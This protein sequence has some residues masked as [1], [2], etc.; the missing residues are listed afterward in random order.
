MSTMRYHSTR[1]KS[2]P[3]SFTE[4]LTGGIAPD[5]GLYMPETIPTRTEQ[6]WKSLAS[7]SYP[8]LVC[9]VLE[10]FVDEHFGQAT[11]Q[12]LAEQSVASFSDPA[13]APLV[14]LEKENLHILEL[15][16]GP[17]L[18]FK[19][20]ALQLLGQLL[21]HAL[22]KQNKRALIIGATSGDTGSAAIEGCRHS[23]RIA[24]FMLHP[25]G[26]VSEVQRRQM[27]TVLAPHIHNLAIETD[28][29]GCQQSVKT[30]L[31]EPGIAL[32]GRSVVAVNSINWARIMAQIVYYVHIALKLDAWNHPLTVVV[33]TGN[34]GNIF[35]A[36]MA[37]RMGVPLHRLIVAT[38]RNDI[39]HR[40]IEQND[41]SR[42]EVTPS[43][44]PSMDIQV[45]S[46][47]ERLLYLLHHEDNA[48]VASLMEQFA[49][50]G[51]MP[52]EPAILTPLREHFSSYRCS[53][54]ETLATIA[55][56]HQH[57]GYLADPHTA[58]AIAAARAH[59]AA[60]PSDGRMVVVATA[61][62]AKFPDAI[63]QAL[64]IEPALPP[65]LSD[66]LS[67]EERY[68]VLPNTLESLREYMASHL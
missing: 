16:H 46:N 44:S 40:F 8:E 49:T 59:Q 14:E 48:A 20:L 9:A 58:T 64:D 50:Q 52:L 21:Q 54:E 42:Q 61:H 10:P 31:R 1:G 34:F 67:R 57:T 60:Q 36:F 4:V 65:H 27:T 29:D 55:S 62:P 53:D 2:A 39:L 51:T 12:T 7:C 38:N 66:L 56:L 25:H 37:R 41:Y 22:E 35:A 17:T 43:L 19:D 28:F 47:L 24:L 23:D 63:F 6:E 30:L 45:S 15:F 33:P 26:R 32:D 68:T 3:L 11:L 13:I 18:A 5:G